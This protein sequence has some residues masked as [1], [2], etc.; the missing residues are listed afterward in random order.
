MSVIK[1]FPGVVGFYVLTSQG[2]LGF[3][4]QDKKFVVDAKLTE[5]F[6]AYLQQYLKIYEK[7]PDQENFR[8]ALIYSSQ[9]KKPWGSET[10]FLEKNIVRRLYPVTGTVTED[11][12]S[13]QTKNRA[14][15]IY[16][17]MELF[18][19]YQDSATPNMPI[20]CP[21][22]YDR[23]TAL[24]DYGPS[25][26]RPVTSV[27]RD[28]SV[29]EVIN[30]LAGIP[31]ARRFASEITILK[32]KIYQ[33]I[34]KKGMRKSTEFTLIEDVRRNVTTPITTEVKAGDSY[35]H[36]DKRS[37][38]RVTLDSQTDGKNLVSGTG[39]SHDALIKNIA[40]SLIGQPEPATATIFK[41]FA[42]FRDVDHS[43]LEALAEKCLIYKA[44][45][46]TQLLERGTKDTMNLYLLE[47][48]VQLI[49]ADGG[50]KFIEGGTPTA[51]NPV[52]SLKPRMYT[53]TAFTRVAFLW[54]DDKLVEEILQAKSALRRGTV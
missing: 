45:P 34:V 52:S 41:A 35:G 44:P 31:V 12:T 13:F 5:V 18:L 46:G 30:I 11:L 3:Y 7:N 28:T 48:S 24:D 17:G 38:R 1:T 39:M 20:Y 27:D 26:D 29:I 40:A 2:Q 42:K 49:A 4:D 47:G 25:L 36:A 8:L 33:G 54:I 32:E 51:Q 23:G 14:K 15:S 37:D 16:R 50:V 22:L 19:E 6:A 21:V 9:E 10:L 43:K 53:V